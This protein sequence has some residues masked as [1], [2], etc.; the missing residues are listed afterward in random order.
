MEDLKS[1]C[2][3]LFDQDGMGAIKDSPGASAYPRLD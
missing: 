2:S 1:F 3:K